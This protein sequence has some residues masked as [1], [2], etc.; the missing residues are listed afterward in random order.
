MTTLTYSNL[1]NLLNMTVSSTICEEIMDHAI[2][3]LNSYGADLPNMTGVAGAKTWN[4]ESREAGAIME[5][6][7]SIYSSK[8]LTSG[9]SSSSVSV[10]SISM[11][12]ST[13]TGSAGSE[14][15]AKDLARQLVEFEVDVG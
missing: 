10:S 15:L 6:A 14:N 11:S 7:C 9:G 12:S 3:L 5:V 1:Q 4:G 8:Y 2:N 13:S